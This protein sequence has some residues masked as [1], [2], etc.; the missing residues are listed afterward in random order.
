MVKKCKWCERIFTAKRLNQNYC[1]KE[2]SRN[3]K[4]KWQ[5]EYEANK[6]ATTE[7]PKKTKRKSNQIT[8]I[9]IAAR[10]A[11]MTYGEYVAKVL[12][13]DSY[14]VQRRK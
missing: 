1:C 9:A 5:R 14:R 12:N 3:G 2:C 10:A 11:G 13:S 6:K 7:K 8:D 4:L